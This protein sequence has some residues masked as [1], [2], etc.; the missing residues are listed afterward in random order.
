MQIYQPSEEEIRGYLDP[1]EHVICTEC[2]RGWDDNLML[3]CDL[4]DSPAHTYC[5]GLGQEVPEGNWYCEGC[6]PVALASLN[7]QAQHSLPDQRTISINMS[8]RSSPSENVGKGL[9]PTT[10]PLTFSPFS[11]GIGSLPSPRYSFGDVLPSPR[12]GAGASTLSGRRHIHRQIRSF[13]SSDRMRQMVG[14]IDGNSAANLGSDYPGLQVDQ[15]METTNQPT[16]TLEVG[17]SYYNF[18]GERLQENPSPVPNGVNLPARSSNFRRQVVQEPIPSTSEGYAHG[19]LQTG[20]NLVSGH[21]QLRQCSSRSSIESDRNVTPFALGEAIELYNDK[22]Q[23]Q[24]T[25]ESYL[26]SISRNL[27]LGMFSSNFLYKHKIV[28]HFAIA[29]LQRMERVV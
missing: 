28:F 18:F 19:E 2:H 22:D 21:E 13:L 23:V 29:F 10:T 4:C 26:K 1:Y 15:G 6:R 16:R 7:S 14:R 9:D 3:L 12:S 17:T 11:R 27:G 25:V 24:S 20:I 5:V 8:H